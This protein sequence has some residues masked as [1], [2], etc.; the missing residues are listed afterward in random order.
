[1]KQFENTYRPNFKHPRYRKLRHF[2]MRA[3]MLWF[4]F[5]Y[6]HKTRTSDHILLCAHTV[7]KPCMNDK[8][9]MNKVLHPFAIC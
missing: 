4:F 6:C 2:F 5:L 1:M 7:S 9:A 8:H 3:L